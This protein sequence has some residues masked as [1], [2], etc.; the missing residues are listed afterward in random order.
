MKS[1]FV[2]SYH[3]FKGFNLTKVWVVI[4]RGENKVYVV[5]ETLHGNYMW[6]SLLG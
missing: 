2:K 3:V 1:H 4:V 5:R 6:Y